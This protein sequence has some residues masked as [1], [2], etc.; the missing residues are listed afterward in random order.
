MSE[1]TTSLG[2]EELS[3]ADASVPGSDVAGRLVRYVARTAA[4]AGSA[5]AQTAG[6]AGRRVA[7]R[8]AR[9][10]KEG[11]ARGQR[12]AAQKLASA[13]IELSRRQQALF[14]RLRERSSGS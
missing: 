8:V 12:A 3:D 10:V 5:A 2:P 14:E 11:A 7:S 4:A 9:G 13:G 1:R 6:R